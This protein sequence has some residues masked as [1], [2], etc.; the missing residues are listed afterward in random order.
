MIEKKYLC[1]RSS[2]FRKR[3]R[4]QRMRGRRWEREMIDPSPPL[5][6]PHSLPLFLSPFLPLSLSFSLPP[7]IPPSILLHLSPLILPSFSLSYSCRKSDWEREVEEDEILFDHS[8]L[9]GLWIISSHP[10]FIQQRWVCIISSH[11]PSP[12][13]LSSLFLSPFCHLALYPPISLSLFPSPL[14]SLPLS[15]SSLSL[16]PSLLSLLCLSSH[17]VDWWLS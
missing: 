1:L 16:P 17:L 14:L 9:F 3:E 10:L 13:V 2:W 8:H 5:S 11:S 12:F 7:S 15:L 4:E 6:L